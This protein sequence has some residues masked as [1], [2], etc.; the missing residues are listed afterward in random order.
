MFDDAASQVFHSAQSF[1]DFEQHIVQLLGHNFRV[2]LAELYNDASRDPEGRNRNKALKKRLSGIPRWRSDM[3][4]RETR[5]IQSAIPDFDTMLSALIVEKTRNFADSVFDTYGPQ[6]ILDSCSINIPP[7]SSSK[8]VH[9]VFSML[10]LRFLSNPMILEENH[11][12]AARII[13]SSIRQV[14]NQ[15]VP[16]GRCASCVLKSQRTEASPEGGILLKR[17]K[18][19][20]SDGSEIDLSSTVHSPGLNVT[21]KVILSDSA[22]GTDMVH[23]GELSSRAAPAAA[24]EGERALG[25]FYQDPKLHDAQSISDMNGS[26]E[27]SQE[28]A[29]KQ[30]STRQSADFSTETQGGGSNQN[31]HR[32]GN[33]ASRQISAS[34]P[35]R[36]AQV[37]RPV[38]RK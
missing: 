20:V 27:F 37:A 30:N 35:A 6:N 3:V 1:L 16:Y 26:A 25:G 22:G 14:L 13:E 21:E 9:S 12:E 29:Q 23:G 28:G 5:L 10:S 33:S 34:E 11:D 17:W 2:A 36:A 7:I 8:F 18:N 15:Y 38:K 32:S 31:K 24:G 19:I 4:E